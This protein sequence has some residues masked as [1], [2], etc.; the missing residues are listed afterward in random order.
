MNLAIVLLKRGD[1]LISQVDEL[2]YEPKCHLVRPH[3]FSGNT[4]L[5]LSSWPE[6]SDD[7]DI[8]IS[9][10]ELLTVV[11]PTEKLR[12][13][14]MTKTGITE[15]DLKPTEKPVILKENNIPSVAE[16]DYEPEFI[17]E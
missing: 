15:E 16:D 11:E 12:K 3:T 4:K 10:E 5:T 9:S 7:T 13:A 14:Y 1:T 8:L 2:D 6:G 17:E